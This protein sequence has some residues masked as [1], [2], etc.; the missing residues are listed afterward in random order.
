[1]KTYR[2]I[3]FEI[4]VSRS[5]SGVRH[6]SHPPPLATSHGATYKSIRGRFAHANLLGRVDKRGEDN[7]FTEVKIEILPEGAGDNEY[8]LSPMKA[9]IYDVVHLEFEPVERLT[10]GCVEIRRTFRVWKVVT[11]M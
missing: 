9:N 7:I 2:C 5:S 1:M 8:N 6:S 3:I 10:C 11:R 4:C